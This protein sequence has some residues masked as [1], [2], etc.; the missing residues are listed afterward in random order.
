M[1]DINK[2]KYTKEDLLRHYESGKTIKQVAK[3]YGVGDET[4][5]A[6]NKI[7]GINIRDY[8]D[9]GRLKKCY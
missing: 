9:F 2:D 8:T 5:R 3:I 4:I 7:Y 6:R 1:I